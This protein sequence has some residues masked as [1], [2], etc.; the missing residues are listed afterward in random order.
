M[1]NMLSN[2]IFKRSIYVLN[3]AKSIIIR[4]SIINN[5]RISYLPLNYIKRYKVTSS[6]DWRPIKTHN[7]PNGTTN[8]KLNI[9]R[10]FAFGL[11][12]TM[13]VV[14]FYLGVWQLRRLSWKTNLIA[15]G[16]TKLTYE[17]VDIPRRFQQRDDYSDWEYRKVKL[18]GKFIYED[19]IFVGPKTFNSEK[20][21]QLFT[22]FQMKG[23]GERFLVERGWISD[24]CVLPENRSL[25]HLSIPQK[26]DMTI[27]CL[28]RGAKRRGKFQWDKK[29]KESRLWQI[30]DIYNMA[31]TVNCPPI[32]F[33]MLYDMKDHPEWM[34]IRDEGNRDKLRTYIDKIWCHW[35]REGEKKSNRKV[36]DDF[37]DSLE[38][39]EWQFMKAGV[40]IGKKPVVEYRNNHFQYLVTWF[41]LSFMSSIYL[42]VALRKYYITNVISQSKL[43]RQQL[44]K[45]QKF[46]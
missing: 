21:Y 3:P 19:E 8:R 45:A 37:N 44:K 25:H 24:K 43:Q 38:F 26:E 40:P 18:T 12:I 31:S 15:D 42:I 39:T 34:E 16:E 32:N 13:P 28:V 22:P 1:N 14:S 29:D 9:W 6:V 20:G 7:N 41:G 30:P 10:F 11:M 27:I 35:K 4:R 17:P 46:I 23:T 2:F 36:N 5:N 33:Q